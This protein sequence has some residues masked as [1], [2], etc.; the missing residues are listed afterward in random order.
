MRRQLLTLIVFLLVF[1]VL[2]VPVA[3]QDTAFSIR[4]IPLENTAAYDLRVAPDGRTAA[5][6]TGQ[7]SLV[8]LGAPV[9]EYQ[10]DPSLL[11][12]RMIDLETG[13]EI[14]RMTDATDY[15]SDVAFSPDGTLLASYHRNGEIYLWDTVSGELQQ[16]LTVVT[17]QGKM[18]FLPDGKTLVTY[19][20]D[21]MVGQFLVWD[22]ETGYMTAVWRTEYSNFGEL[23]L[24][25]SPGNFDYRYAT[26]ALSPDGGWMATATPNGELTLWDTSTLVQSIVQSRG[27]EM[28][29]LMQFNIRSMAFSPDSQTLIY[30]DALREQTVFWDIASHAPALTFSGG[31]HF[32]GVSPDMRS[33]VWATRQEVW[34]ARSDQPDSVAKVLDF[35]ANLLVG[36]PS[37]TFT[38][39]GSS[40]IVGGFG[41]RD[42]VDNLIY[43]ITFE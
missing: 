38:P 39:D 42:E 8:L 3:A 17:G 40:V 12:I 20:A 5:V 37:V 1:A 11:P 35:E 6:F 19:L 9:I 36:A 22:I 15:I 13:A 34:F 28:S 41:T 31:S 23:L 27:E 24:S 4:T 2:V 18:A 33:L 16:R 14:A 30:Y 21:S 26:F 29:E 25:R 10:V 43:V 32:F 7:T